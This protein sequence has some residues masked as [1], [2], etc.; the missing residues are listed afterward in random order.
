MKILLFFS[1]FLL[2]QNCSFDN[3]SGI[4]TNEK[5]SNKEKKIF[6][7]FETLSSVENLFN[8]I[9]PYNG[10]HV[11]IKS[12]TKINSN[13]PDVNYNKTNNFDNFQYS[14]LNQLLFKSRQ[15]LRAKTNKDILFEGGNLITSDKKGNLVVYSLN[16]K[17]IV[18]KFNFYKK[19]YKKIK[20]TLFL[21]A[22]NNIIYVSDNLG[23]L[24]AFDYVS[25]KVLWA[26]NYKIPF[27]SN[28]KVLNN[29]IVAANQN[30]NLY[31]FKKK[32]GEVARLIPT[33]ETIVNNAFVNNI[34][35]SEKFSLFLNTYGSLY[36]VDNE[37]LNIRWFINLNQSTDLNLSN[38]FLGSKIINNGNKIVISSN[39]FTYVLNNNG[40]II[41]KKNFTSLIKPLI[42]NDCLFLITKNNLLISM[43]LNNGDII[44]SYDINKKI[45]EFLKIKKKKVA[46]KSLITANNSIYI[47]LENSYIIKFKFNGE[48]EKVN[49]LPSKI[50]SNPIFINKSLLYLDKKNKLF[51]VS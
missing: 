43:N 17:K 37:T 21:A 39:N 10:K 36:A 50:H 8:E 3:K 15:L 16:Q 20:K 24:Y 32:T 5:L 34:S 2:L 1:I 46:L 6:S 47:F 28:L 45:A 14:G 44:Y 49:K 12:K 26:K 11:F 19:R 41:Y 25:E 4:W 23:Y 38:L 18:S 29:I 30:N 27:R 33:E 35:F 7:D 31:F 48:I 13:W 9:I 42:V 22:E 51:V 40:S